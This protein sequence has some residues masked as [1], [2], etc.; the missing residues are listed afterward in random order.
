MKAKVIEVKFEHKYMYIIYEVYDDA[1]KLLDQYQL[2][3]E[4]LNTREDVEKVVRGALR[5]NL[6][7]YS[8]LSK[9]DRVT[10][11]NLVSQIEED[12]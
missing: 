12:V 11:I 5:A 2:Q 3:H 6:Q 1:G 10:L 8:N 4:F 7:A 9:V